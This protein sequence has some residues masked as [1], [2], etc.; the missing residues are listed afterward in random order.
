[1][2]TLTVLLFALVLTASAATVTF[3]P[4][5]SL[6]KDAH[7]F[8]LTPDTNYG[9]LALINCGSASGDRYT[10]YIEFTEL[11]DPQ[12]QDATVYSAT[13][14]L[15]VRRVEGSSAYQFVGAAV[16]SSWDEG[17]ITWNNKPG[18]IAGSGTYHN[19]P[20]GAGWIDIDITTWVQNW[21]DGT[22]TNNGVYFRAYS[23]GDDQYMSSRSSDYTTDPT[24]RPKL[25]LDYSGVAVEETTW[26]EIKAEF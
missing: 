20:S 19:Y 3:Q 24:L 17:T 1:M 10:I 14:S 5:P 16:G 8:E 23:G 7:V 22:W 25:V 4:Y 21:L 6:G 18:P 12:Y 15:Y 11:N 26:G 9:D 13:L 2:R